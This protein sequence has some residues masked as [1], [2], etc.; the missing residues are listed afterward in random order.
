MVSVLLATYNGVSTIGRFLGALAQCQPP[1]DDWE[2]IVV[3]NA[4]NDSTPEVARAFADKIPLRVLSHPVRGKN[5]ALNRGLENVRGEVVVL[6]DDDVL[7]K[8]D[9]LVAIQGRATRHPEVDLFGGPILPHWDRAPPPWLDSAV[10]FG[11]AFAITA[12]DL[13]DGA[14][15]PRRI[16]GPNMF[17]RRRVFDAGLRFDESRGPGPGQY[18]MG[19]ETEFTARA[20]AAGHAAWWCPEI[21]VHHIIRA[22]QLERGWL[23]KRAYR[24]GKTVFLLSNRD[25][26]ADPSRRCGERF[27]PSLLRRAAGALLKGLVYDLIRDRAPALCHWWRFYQLRGYMAQAKAERRASSRSRESLPARLDL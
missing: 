22:E 13:P 11:V 7:P 17:V 24:Y 19:S 2:V 16:W 8:S 12:I 26:Q 18:V 1:S 20:A 25:C 10:P 6:T 4:S 5:R 9:W 14:V 21:Q 15:N 3:D 27:S 23:L